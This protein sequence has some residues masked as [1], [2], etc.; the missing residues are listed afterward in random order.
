MGLRR[1]FLILIFF[2]FSFFIWQNWYLNKDTNLVKNE[3]N[4]IINK[5]LDV[6]NYQNFIHVKTDV[7]DV[8]INKNNGDIEKV[9][10]LKYNESLNSNKPFTLLKNFDYFT[11]IAH[12]GISFF[13]KNSLLFN[14]L[15]PSDNKS[16]NFNYLINA[17]DDK[18]QVPIS[19]KSI[20]GNIIYNKI[21]VFKKGSYDISVEHHILNNSN[22]NLEFS[23][24]GELKQS[25]N[26]P[27]NSLDF[28]NKNLT[29]SS[30]RGAAYSSD[31]NKYTKYKFDKIENNHN[32]NIITKSGWIAML[33]RYFVSAWIPDTSLINNFYTFKDNK[34]IAVIG[35]KSDKIILKSKKNYFS[36]SILWVGPEIQ[37]IM[38]TISPYLDLTVDYGFLWFLSQPLFKVLSFLYSLLGNWGWSIIA[39]TF[40]MKA[41]MYP[42]TKS[43]YVSMAKMRILQPKIDLIKSNFK[44]DQQRI[45]KEIM[46]LY[47]REKL[48]PF[49]GC[50]P[51]II[52]M[53]IFLALYYM[54]MSSIELRHA[55]FLFWIKD[56]SS[57]DPY[58]LLPVLMG[59]TM[60]FIQKMSP[61]SVTDPLQ[62]KIMNFMP[63]I[64]TVFFLWFPSGLVLYYI[65]S[66]LVTI[67]QQKLIFKILNKNINLK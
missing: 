35:Y 7:L 58:F 9:S 66:N 23:I 18:L 1:N 27:K 16:N 10:L 4:N 36:Q 2:I 67:I 39:I 15:L 29:I 43:Q 42:L 62:K 30:F 11:Y 60:F 17:K 24:F 48:N 33:E 46:D 59:I 61:S 3:N 63:V 52:Q 56:L 34:D 37:N 6:F 26:L 64:F 40:I 51:V 47:K 49:S 22:K 31:T 20:D 65:T 45:S 53:P 38:S 44:N 12:S 8:F 5:D 13:D 41:I 50:F 19:W 28:K 55:Y 57:Q 25:I 14:S 21:Y 54:L 32:L